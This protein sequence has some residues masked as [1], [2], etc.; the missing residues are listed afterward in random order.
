MHIPSGNVTL[1]FTS[2]ASMEL[3]TL[4]LLQSEQRKIKGKADSAVS[5]SV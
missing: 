4:M 5:E 3:L 2:Y 1:L